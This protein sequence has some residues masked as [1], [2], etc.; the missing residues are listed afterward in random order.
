MILVLG[1][2][3]VI[4]NINDYGYVRIWGFKSRTYISI[5]GIPGSKIYE[6][7]GN[8][9]TEIDSVGLHFLGVY[10]SDGDG[11]LEMYFYMKLNE[12]D[13]FYI[14][15]ADSLGRFEIELS[16]AV[17]KHIASGSNAMMPVPPSCYVG[18][19]DRDGMKDLVCVPYAY[20][21]SVVGC[22][23][24]PWAVMIESYGDNEW[25]VKPLL[26]GNFGYVSPNMLDSDGDGKLEFAFG[27]GIVE[28]VGNDSAEFAKRWTGSLGYPLM[29][30]DIDNDG[31]PEILFHSRRGYGTFM[32]DYVRIYEADGD[33]NWRLISNFS[34]MRVPGLGAD[35]WFSTYGDI[36]LDG[37][38]EIIL[39]TLRAIV[40]I[41]SFG[42]NNF[43]VV[44]TLPINYDFKTVSN[45]LYDINGNGYKEIA[46]GVYYGGGRWRVT[47]YEYRPLSVGEGIVEDEG[48]I[49]GKDYIKVEG[50]GELRVYDALGRL[51]KAEKVD[52][53]GKVSVK[54]LPRGVYFVKFKGKVLK[55]I[56]R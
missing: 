53:K 9:W 4:W 46:V 47:G 25:E 14:F 30:P 39:N 27:G 7:D 50:R 19:A 28:I 5:G 22:E 20:D 12:A 6:W 24:C 21:S 16:K 1:Q 56:R 13:T 11:R 52:G 54:E 51:V 48:L 18:D 33:N 15:E 34:T 45:G 10:D 29:L 23:L 49:V 26:T 17:Y 36:D 2:F 37:Q 42:D 38:Y 8:R 32:Q 3:S 35:I 31:K 40:I 43:Q 55:F 44:D 41:K